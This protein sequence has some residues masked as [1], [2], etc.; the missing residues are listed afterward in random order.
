[1]RFVKKTHFFCI[2]LVKYL[3]ISKK[4]ITFAPDF[5]K[6]IT[7]HQ[8]E[9]QK[10]TK[11]KTI[12]ETAQTEKREIQLATYNEGKFPYTVYYWSRKTAHMYGSSFAT[13]EEARAK[14]EEIRKKK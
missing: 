14:F 8:K 6:E 1:M 13:L 2:F 12:I 10:E 4:S 9:T 11:M 3:H 7:K 5:K